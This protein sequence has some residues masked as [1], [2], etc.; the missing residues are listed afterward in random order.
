MTTDSHTRRLVTLGIAIHVILISLAT[1][2][3]LHK[4]NS[5]VN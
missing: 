3:I 5:E 4:Q 1:T 2:V